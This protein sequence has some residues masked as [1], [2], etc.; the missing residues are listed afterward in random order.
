MSPSS[1]TNRRRGTRRVHDPSVSPA[2]LAVWRRALPGLML[3]A[4]IGLALLALPF[5]VVTTDGPWWRDAGFVA[6]AVCAGRSCDSCD[7]AATRLRLAGAE[8]EI[9]RT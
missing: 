2:P 4:A 7:R 9:V 5:G 6:L 1:P 8:V 3:R